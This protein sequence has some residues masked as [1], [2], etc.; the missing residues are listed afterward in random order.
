MPIL[1][2]HGSMGWE[3]EGMKRAGRAKSNHHYGGEG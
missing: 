1:G 3:D 2:E